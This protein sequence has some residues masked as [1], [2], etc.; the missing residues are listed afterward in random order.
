[1]GQSTSERER[2][3]RGFK[4]LAKLAGPASRP[5]AS[6]ISGIRRTDRARRP[7]LGDDR[8]RRARGVGS[9][10]GRSR[11]RDAAR[12]RRRC[13]RTSRSRRPRPPLSIGPALPAPASPLRA[14]AAPWSASPPHRRGRRSRRHRSCASVADVASV[15]RSAADRERASGA[16][17]RCVAEPRSRLARAAQRRHRVCGDRRGRV[18]R[19]PPRAR[20]RRGEL[21][22]GGYCRCVTR[23]RSRPA[24]EQRP[25]RRRPR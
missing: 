18:L 14:A 13:S 7:R 1:M 16:E 9:W 17:R 23:G 20:A 19:R 4:E 3:R 5:K 10:R 21:A 6:S 22:L 24:Q 15:G 11:E 25:S 12:V 2:D 8:S